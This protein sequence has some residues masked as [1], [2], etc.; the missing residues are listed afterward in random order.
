MK[1]FLTAPP[2]VGKSTIIDTVVRQYPGT[3]RG[4]VA[5]EVLDDAGKRQGFT[6]FNAAC[7]SRQFMFRAAPGNGTVG[8]FS[9]D[10]QAIDEFVVPELRTALREDGLV[11]ADEI[12]RAQAKSPAFLEALREL[13]RSDKP[14]LASIVY[15]DEP[16]SMEFKNNQ[17][18]CILEVNLH[19]RDA[20]PGILLAAFAH[21]AE[22]AQLNK[23]QQ[24]TT[25]NWLRKL[26]SEGHLVAARK[27]FDNALCYVTENK[28]APRASTA[29]GER[30]EVAGKTRSHLIEHHADG[31]FTCDCDLSNGRGAFAQAEPCSHQLSLLISRVAV[32]QS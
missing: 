13:V 23:D 28:I 7:E 3:T 4:I 24:V 16:W 5:R 6:S 27:L 1:L 14:L 10:V 30:F 9:V 32:K 20:L 18:V 12:G 29:D 25:Q 19:N 22:F 8:D 31:S 15:D 11:Y 26:V 2:G 17:N 21:T